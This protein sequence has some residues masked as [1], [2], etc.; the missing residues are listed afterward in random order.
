MVS[1]TTVSAQ[2]W[3]GLVEHTQWASKSEPWAG[4]LE[5]HMYVRMYHVP[6]IDFIYH[7][8]AG[9][10]EAPVSSVL[11][12]VGRGEV[13]R[14]RRERRRAECDPSRT[15]VRWPSGP[16]CLA[17]PCRDATP[18]TFHSARWGGP[19]LPGETVLASCTGLPHPP[20]VGTQQVAPDPM[21][22]VVRFG[23]LKA[24]CTACCLRKFRF[25]RAMDA[26]TSGSALPGHVELA[27]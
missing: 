4:P 24:P 1:R 17:R 27:S 6:Q 21:L 8:A 13:P 9:R 11:G 19:A 16:R 18:G 23:S 22:Q 10:L 3:H 25:T 15:S 2:G 12:F 14:G 26:C 20:A 7:V 5:L